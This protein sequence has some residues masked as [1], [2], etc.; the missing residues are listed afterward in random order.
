MAIDIVL[1]WKLS[2]GEQLDK[3]LTA[4]QE[5]V[6]EMCALAKK[7]CATVDEILLIAEEGCLLATGPEELFEALQAI[8]KKCKA[9]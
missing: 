5:L 4:M 6:S 2:Q 3:N 7:S 8:I 9:E 1:L